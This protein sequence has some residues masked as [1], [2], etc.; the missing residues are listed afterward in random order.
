[1]TCLRSLSHLIEERLG[2]RIC[3]SHVKAHCGHAGNEIA[4]SLA[5]WA[6]EN[7]IEEL[8]GCLHSCCEGHHDRDLEW[9]FFLFKKELAPFWCSGHLFLPVRPHTQSTIDPA[10]DQ[11]ESP[12][13]PVGDECQ[14]KVKITSANVLTLLP[15]SDVQAGLLDSAR[16]EAILKQ[17]KEADINI[18]SLQETRLRK[19][20]FRTTKDFW[21][22]QGAAERGHG[23]TLLAFN[24]IKPYGRVGDRDKALFFRKEHFAIIH[25]DPRILIVKVKAPGLQCLCASLH[26]PQSGQHDSNIRAWWEKLFAAIPFQYRT[27]PLLAAGDFNARVGSTP[28]A[29]TGGHQGENDNLN[30]EL[31]Q[32]WLISQA[33]W[34]PSTWAQCHHGPA[35]TWQHSSGKW[36]RLDYICL[37]VSFKCECSWVDLDL[38]LALKRTDH[39]AVSAEISTTTLVSEIK[40]FFR[41]PR[42]RPGYRTTSMGCLRSDPVFTLELMFTPTPSS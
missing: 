30:G 14:I 1:M 12:V 36:S 13:T 31:F 5:Y 25:S 8:D 42:R 32:E 22:V 17:A 33:L 7:A 37:P 35:G 21:I 19:S 29:A 40:T 41:G 26:A 9:L 27:W 6:A 16:Q 18:L 11:E 38:D 15:G 3:G 24:R 23:G 4:N 10:Y 39:L 2:C 20:A 34:A 28:T